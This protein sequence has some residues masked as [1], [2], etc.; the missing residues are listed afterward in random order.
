MENKKQ[1]E[2]MKNKIGNIEIIQG[3]LTAM[4]LDII[5]NAA[6]HTLLGGGGIDGIIHYKAGPKLLEECR[7]TSRQVGGK[8]K[9]VAVS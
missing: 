2:F 3:D 6:N 1:G 4:N 9:S 8:F 5:V 7:S